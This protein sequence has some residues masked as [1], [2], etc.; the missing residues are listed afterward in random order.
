MGVA[1]SLA[2]VGV[3]ILAITLAVEVLGLRFL[4]GAVLPYVAVAVFLG[5][6]VYRLLGWGRSP[7]PFRIPTTGGQQRSLPWIKPSSLDNPSSTAGVIG[8]M[9]LE[10]LLFRSLF[11]NTKAEL[12]GGPHLAYHWEKWLW[13][14]ALVFHWSMLLVV[15]RHLRFFT[16]PVPSFVYWVEGI[17]G[18]LRVGLRALYL[19]DITLLL[20]VTY[21]LLRR[22][23]IPQ[24]RYISLP[25]DYVPLFLLL[26]IGLSGVLMR[27]F[28]GVDVAAVKEL[29]LGVLTF[30]PRIPEGIGVLFY[31]HWGLVCALLA[32][33]PFSKL[34]HMGGIFL[35]PTRNLPN[36]SR[37]RRHVNPW[38]YPVKV[39]TYE[40]YEEEFR[41]KMKL[42]GI[43]VE[44]E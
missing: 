29:A 43:P 23:F 27:Y 4:V 9:A 14:G 35:T 25:G 32:Y 11:R 10:I 16:D 15:I 37:A 3:L 38:N 44:K 39:H 40:E 42:A 18:F 28:V 21:L 12:H 5:G 17:D 30:R 19:T 13:L 24:V 1:F 2:V 8:R 33:F 41:E 20:G 31:I 26:G 34:V 6:M 7:V 22:F 36:D